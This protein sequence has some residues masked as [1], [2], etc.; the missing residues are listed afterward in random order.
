MERI[1]K[2]DCS[3]E[4]W[5]DFIAA[6]KSGRNV[7]IDEDLYNYWCDLLAP[8]LWGP[9]VQGKRYDFACGEGHNPLVYFWREGERYFCRTFCVGGGNNA[10]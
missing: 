4:E 1:Y 7:A 5:A 2:L 10:A 9:V 6:Q 8:R 3:S